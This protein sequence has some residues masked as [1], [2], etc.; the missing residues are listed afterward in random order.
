M[1]HFP[2]DSCHAKGAFAFLD[3]RLTGFCIIV[4]PPSS[5]SFFK[6]LLSYTYFS[7]PFLAPVLRQCVSLQTLY[8]AVMA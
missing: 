4:L 2:E 6:F 8:A 1:G 7:A 5:N 3:L